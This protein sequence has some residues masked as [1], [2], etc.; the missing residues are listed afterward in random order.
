MADEPTLTAEHTAHGDMGDSPSVNDNTVVYNA[1]A[2]TANME[3]SGQLAS[4]D[5]GN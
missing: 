1:G 3:E 5:H 4:V 2:D